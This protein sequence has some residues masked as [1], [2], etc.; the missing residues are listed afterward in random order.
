LQHLD[1]SMPMNRGP[2]IIASLVIALFALG[3]GEAQPKTF[4]NAWA[5]CG[6]KYM[7]EPGRALADDRREFLCAGKRVRAMSREDAY[8]ACSKQFGATSIMLFWTRKGWLC[9]YRG[10]GTET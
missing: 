2:K 1:E 5:A 4:K 7:T 8:H 10:Y 3:A 9:H 6:S